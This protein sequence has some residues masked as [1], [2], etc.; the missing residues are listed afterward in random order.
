[1]SIPLRWPADWARTAA[2]D[3]RSGRQFVCTPSTALRELEGNLR[4]LG[5]T[6]AVVSSWLP[7]GART[8]A[9]RLDMA[10]TALP[11]PGVCLA[12]VRADREHV[13][14]RD[15]FATVLG[16]LRSIGLAIE[17]LRAMERHG[18]TAIL[19]RAFAGFVALPDRAHWRTVLGAAPGLTLGEIE[20]RYR[21]LAKQANGGHEELV[22]L[23]LAIEAARRELGAES[24][25][26]GR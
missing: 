26:H 13:L 11:D 20:A 8:G 18:G 12:F 2:A 17:G 1:M 5:I 21:Q 15:A 25:E 24:R 4:G 23:N 3:R 19:D 22:S 7:V 16:N 6:Y 14:A 9:M 10:R